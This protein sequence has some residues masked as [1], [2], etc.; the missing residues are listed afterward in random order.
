MS[1][2]TSAAPLETIGQVRNRV[3]ELRRLLAKLEID[4]CRTAAMLAAA[5]Q[6]FDSEFRHL[7]RLEADAALA[8]LGAVAVVAF[9]EG[10]LR[11]GDV[12]TQQTMLQDMLGDVDP[13]IAARL[14]GTIGCDVYRTWLRANP[15]R[16]PQSYVENRGDVCVRAMFENDVRTGAIRDDN[17]DQVL[18][19]NLPD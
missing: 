8:V 10:K 9:K 18:Y 11:K 4:A 7:C 3:D 12:L 16:Y 1:A 14:K 15:E 13:E 6:L 19:A 2:I 5:K 17:R